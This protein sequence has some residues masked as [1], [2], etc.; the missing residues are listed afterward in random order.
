MRRLAHFA[1]SFQV[2]TRWLRRA[3][4]IAG[5]I[6]AV[7]ALAPR[8]AAQTAVSPARFGLPLG[9]VEL[10]ARRTA[11]AKHY[12]Q[13]DG[14]FVAI[15][16][17]GPLHY[18]DTTGIWQDIDPTFRADGAGGLIS[19]H[20]PVQID[21]TPN[22]QISVTQNGLGVRWLTPVTLAQ[23]GRNVVGGTDAKGTQWQWIATG[24][25]LKLGATVS[26]RQRATDL[27]VRLRIVGRDQ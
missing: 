6:A 17:A 1:A 12:Q 22:G 5:L 19:D 20:A 2:E 27:S 14:S 23:Q 4:P 26:S 9:A 3:L 21:A 10:V 11:N 15:V 13:P 18:R 8:A 7:F 16:G 24:A 25:G